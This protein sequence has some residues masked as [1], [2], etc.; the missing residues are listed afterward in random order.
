[1]H[2]DYVSPPTAPP[3]PAQESY[4]QTKVDALDDALDQLTRFWNERWQPE[5]FAGD[6]GMSS[7]TSS[8]PTPHLQ[9][10]SIA[11]A[12]AAAAREHRPSEEYKGPAWWLDV[13]CPSV[14]D[15]RTLR[16]V[17]DLRTCY[18]SHWQQAHTGS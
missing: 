4:Q 3:H 17:S 9:G 18:L 14:Q 2:A 6:L 16:K 11:A 8:Q 10:P 7:T 5:A 15:M 12:A 1:M 13:L